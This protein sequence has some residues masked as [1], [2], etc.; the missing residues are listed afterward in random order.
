MPPYIAMRSNSARPTNG[1]LALRVLRPNTACLYCRERRANERAVRLLCFARGDLPD[2]SADRPPRALG[3]GSVGRTGT[4][5]FRRA[6]RSI[7][8]SRSS[9]GLSIAAGRGA[10]RMRRPRARTRRDRWRRPGL[11]VRVRRDHRP[12]GGRDLHGHRASEGPHR[13]PGGQRGRDRLGR[14]GR[15]GRKCPGC[16]HRPHDGD[17][18]ER[19]AESRSRGPGLA[20]ALPAAPLAGLGDPGPDHGPHLR[21]RRLRR[22]AP[23]GSELAA[24]RALARR[25]G[26]PAFGRRRRLQL[27]GELGTR[28]NDPLRGRRQRRLSG[29][30][31][32]GHGRTRRRGDRARTAAR[33]TSSRRARRRCT[34]RS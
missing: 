8:V 13:R 17:D 18:R 33:S 19:P 5:R 21:H 1:R 30:L 14:D 24:D 11:D 26:R 10:R 25:S 31:R 29:S 2:A 12:T 7:S 3:Q 23:L 6:L 20:R 9:T 28:R 4:P 16:P 34:Q 32:A 22:P 15:I 27:R